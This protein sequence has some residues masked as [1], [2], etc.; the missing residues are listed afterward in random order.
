MPGRIITEDEMSSRK[1]IADLKLAI[2]HAV[3]EVHGKT[4]LTAIELVIALH[5]QQ[6]Y[7]LRELWKEDIKPTGV[8][9][10]TH[11]NG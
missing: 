11:P 8:T 5:Q 9:A 10:A 6:D 2:S 1:R 4:P 3:G 7:W